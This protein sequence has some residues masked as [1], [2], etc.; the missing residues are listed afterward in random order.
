MCLFWSCASWHNCVVL[1]ELL[2]LLQTSNSASSLRISHW[3]S[4][5]CANIWAW[6]PCYIRLTVTLLGHV[7]LIILTENPQSS[8]AA[9]FDQRES[10]DSAVCSGGGEFTPEIVLDDHDGD[11]SAKPNSYV[12]AIWWAFAVLQ[13]NAASPESPLR[14]ERWRRTCSEM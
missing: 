1:L 5:H 12:S 14:T 13:W 3:I 6:A 9:T 10:C 7:S 4:R 11:I 8:Q 2:P